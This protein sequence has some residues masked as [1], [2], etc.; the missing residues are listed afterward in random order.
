MTAKEWLQRYLNAKKEI[1]RL[2]QVLAEVRASQANI[3]AIEYSDMP[4]YPSVNSDLS[5]GIIKCEQMEEKIE[6]KRQEQI[7]ILHEVTAVIDQ[8]S[9]VDQRTVLT[10]RYLHG[11]GWNRISG[12]MDKDCRTVLRIHGRALE[13]VRKILAELQIVT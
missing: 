13:N 9:D 3:K 12:D 6:R 4:R 10:L 2:V 11:A 8:I 1:N 5:A 7:D